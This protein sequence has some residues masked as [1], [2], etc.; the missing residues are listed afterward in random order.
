MH[1]KPRFCST[2]SMS[3]AIWAK[4][5]IRSARASMRGSRAASGATS[6]VEVHAAV[7]QG[8]PHAGRQESVEDVVGG[9]QTAQHGLCSQG[10]LW[11]TV[12]LRTRRLGSTVLRAVA[13]Q[14]QVA[15]AQAL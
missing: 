5:W 15:T 13:R 3:S 11:P 8:E 12:E 14:S 2:N 9:Q 6:R 1:R 10:E 7:A 4:R